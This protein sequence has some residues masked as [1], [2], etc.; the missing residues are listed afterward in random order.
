MR[1]L[2]VSDSHSYYSTLEDIL[3]RERSADMVIHLG[4][5]A[6]DMNM[7]DEYVAGKPV[8]ICRGNCDL[9]GND[10]AEQHV[11]EL[12]GKKLLCCHG[13]R[14]HVKDGIYALYAAAREQ[15][16]D[17]CLFGHTHSARL[18]EENGIFIL[19]PGA[20]CNGDYAVIDI[21][22]DEIKITQKSV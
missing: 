15:E 8:V 10:Y 16:A 21:K 11:F 9:Y 1:I 13:H 14:Y 12:E 6:D 20:V 19:N 2:V 7:M 3:K 4:D 5:F 18:D 17:I 22:N